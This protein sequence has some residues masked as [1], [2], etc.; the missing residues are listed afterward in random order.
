M[1]KHAIITGGSSGIGKAIAKLLVQS[2]SSISIIART[3]TKLDS[4][5][6]ELETLKIHPNQQILAIFADVSEREQIESAIASAIMQLGV[7]DL[8]ITSAG[9]AH[10][11]YFAELPVAIFEQT[12]AINYFGTL[13]CIKAALPSMIQQRKGHIVAISS[14]AGL[15]GL[16]GYTPYS[17]SKF[18]V[19]GLAESLR[20]E[21][22]TAGIDIS[23]VYPPDT[24]TP[25]LVA[26]NKTKPLE[27]KLITQSAQTMTAEKVAFDIL[28]GIKRKAFVITPGIEMSLLMRFHSLF[29]PILQWYFDRIV[30]R[31]RHIKEPNNNNA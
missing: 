5:K 9:I 22:K 16:Y 27:T 14:G 29:A 15:I 24:D 20:G 25:Q 30:R 23:I 18:A 6:A 12:M 10:P 4:T 11:G 21:L 3:Q 28:L 7:P 31:S 1:Y 2:G 13:Y 8:L 17:P 26:E 19:R